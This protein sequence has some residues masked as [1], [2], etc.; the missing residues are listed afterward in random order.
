MTFQIW[1]RSNA[2]A[3]PREYAGGED[4]KRMRAV[5]EMLKTS[6]MYEELELRQQAFPVPLVR[7]RRPL[8]VAS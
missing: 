6:G 3:R 1:G 4:E 8:A 2:D 7:W 5:F